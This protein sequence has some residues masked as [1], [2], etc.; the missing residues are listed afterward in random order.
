MWE[1]KS[2]RNGRVNVLTDE[3]HREMSRRGNFPAKNFIITELQLKN[4]VPLRTEEKV[5]KPKIIK[6]KE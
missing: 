4:I 2:K 6:K 1:W 5:I 3:E